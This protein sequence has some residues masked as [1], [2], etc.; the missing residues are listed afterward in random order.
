MRKT[1]EKDTSGEKGTC[2]TKGK[3]TSDENID[4]LL[5]TLKLPGG[6]VHK[7]TLLKDPNLRGKYFTICIFFQF[8]QWTDHHKQGTRV[9]QARISSYVGISIVPHMN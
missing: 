5:T 9:L 1:K 4:Q 8:L 7:F 2:K 3:E 6:I